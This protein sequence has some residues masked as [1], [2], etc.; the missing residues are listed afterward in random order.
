MQQYMVP[1]TVSQFYSVS[2]GTGF[3]CIPEHCHFMQ[4]ALLLWRHSCC[5]CYS[6]CCCLETFDIRICTITHTMCMYVA[7]F[8]LH[9]RLLRIPVGKKVWHKT[10][11]ASADQL[12]QKSHS[13]YSLSSL[14]FSPHSLQSTCREKWKKDQGHKH[15]GKQAPY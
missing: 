3:Y 5:M 7:L 15:N 11:K 14:F 4:D 8:S 6:Q 2:E 1:K 13:L 9:L 10:S 12:S